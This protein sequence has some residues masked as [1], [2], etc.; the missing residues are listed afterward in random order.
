[1]T[2][3]PRTSKSPSAIISAGVGTFSSGDRLASRGDDPC[4]ELRPADVDRKTGFHFA[5]PTLPV[6][7][8]VPC[9]SGRRAGVAR[10]DPFVG[11]AALRR[12]PRSCQVRDDAAPA[13]A[14]LSRRKR[15]RNQSALRSPDGRSARSEGV[16]DVLPAGLADPAEIGAEDDKGGEHDGDAEQ[17]QE[18]RRCEEEDHDRQADDETGH[19]PPYV[20][21]RVPIDT[22]GLDP[23]GKRRIV[24]V[25]RLLHLVEHTLLFFGER[26]AHPL[27][28]PATSEAA[29]T[30]FAQAP[31][32][33]NVAYRWPISRSISV[34]RQLGRWTVLPE[35]QGQR[36]PGFGL[37]LVWGAPPRAA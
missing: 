26:H 36:Y 12:D 8:R 28:V 34:P 27:S 31:Y 10:G 14:Y 19:G 6:T 33:D 13:T 7:A 35:A 21:A 17:T 29:D 4:G 16:G 24:P 1:M 23:R 15:V 32:R 20:A 22:L 30:I 9:P 2:R 25:K 11:R 37:Q 3:S 18:D 5:A